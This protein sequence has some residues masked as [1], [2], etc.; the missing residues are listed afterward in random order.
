[1]ANLKEIRNRIGSVK[2]TRKI[3]SA[4]SRI[5][6]AR[7]RKAQN[8]MTRAQVYADRVTAMAREVVPGVAADIHPYLER[9]AVKRVGVVVVTADRG[10]CGGFNGG[11][12]RSAQS[13]IEQRRDAGQQ[14]VVVA[15][16]RKGAGFLRGRGIAVETVHTAPEPDTAVTL[17]KEVA[18]SAFAMFG[19]DE[20]Q[21]VDEVVLIYNHFKNVLTQEVTQLTLLPVTS[22]ADADASSEKGP[23]RVFEPSVPALLA[24]LLPLTVETHLQKAMFHSAAA[25]VAA[26]RTAMDAATD[27]ASELIGEL[28]LEY[29]RE[30]QAAI[31]KELM[32]II[33]GSEALK[34]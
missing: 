26:R 3:T 27:N 34:S 15:V 17:A 5:A 2:N 11:V 25:E 9:R 6:A 14:V 8:A 21:R 7:L 30:R 18:A 12:G 16:G 28:T 4:M 22:G 33:G 29:N 13:L 19:A 23:E 24:T 10:L 31:T 20:E 1:M 32:E